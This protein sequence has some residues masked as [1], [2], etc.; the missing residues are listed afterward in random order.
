M[1]QSKEKDEI[2]FCMRWEYFLPNWKLI[3]T[4]SY[5]LPQWNLDIHILFAGE[6]SLWKIPSLRLWG[7]QNCCKL[8]GRCLRF[9]FS[10]HAIH[11][12]CWLPMPKVSFSFICKY[13]YVA[14][15]PF[16][17]NVRDASFRGASTSYRTCNKL[18]ILESLVI[19]T[20]VCVHYGEYNTGKTSLLQ[21]LSAMHGIKNGKVHRKF[22][23][24]IHYSFD[25]LPPQLQRWMNPRFC[26]FSLNPVAATSPLMIHLR[27]LLIK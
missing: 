8:A 22:I 19:S 27:E 23:N 3:I 14:G 26:W 7:W 1:L 5:Q 18:L 20:P 16:C 13:W 24:I 12:R 21:C 6:T 17:Q 11:T 25:I 15:R 9:Y 10:V 4:R 2:D